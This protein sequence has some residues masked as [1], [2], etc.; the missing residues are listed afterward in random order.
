MN[1]ELV[2][3]AVW[4]VIGKFTFKEQSVSIGSNGKRTALQNEVT[5]IQSIFTNIAAEIAVISINSARSEILLGNRLYSE[6]TGEIICC[7][8]EQEHAFSTVS[9]PAGSNLRITVAKCY[10]HLIRLN[11][12]F[13]EILAKLLVIAGVKAN[14][15][16]CCYR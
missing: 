6:C 9:C 16:V 10:H 15:V 2:R 8:T 4:I 1:L 14:I 13:N 5:V 11:A 3:L 12:L 7:G